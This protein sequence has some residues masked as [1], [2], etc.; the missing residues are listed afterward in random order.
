MKRLLLL[1]IV[2]GSVV[3][4]GAT[5]CPAYAKGATDV[6]VSG[7]GM[8]KTVLGYTR[9]MDD[10]DVGSLAEASGI[11]QIFGA[12]IATDDPGLSKEELGPRYVL[13]WYQGS[14][15]MAVS[16]VYPFTS[17]GAWARIPYEQGGWVRGG[18]DLERAMVDLGALRP[19][20]V[21]EPGVSP[22]ST[23][24]GPDS[25]G[26]A[27]PDGT[28]NSTGGTAGQAGWVGLAALALLTGGGAWLLLRRSVP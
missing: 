19:Q 16:H 25:A 14:I 2:L 23:T 6:H 26:V 7:P 12:A 15:I 24:A 28:T 3:L 21:A 13:T 27:T 5:S 20:D 1:T 10:V 18:P 9:R 8:D 17:Q 11:Y 4:V 22:S